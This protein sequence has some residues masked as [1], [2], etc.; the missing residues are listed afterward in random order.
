M[1]GMAIC[2]T[3]TALYS[4]AVQGEIAS[5]VIRLHVLANSDSPEDQALK[6]RVRDAVLSELKT[7]LTG[8]EDLKTTRAVLENHIPDIKRAAG[9][10]TDYPVE[11]S[12]TREFFPTRVYGGVTLP[13]GVYETLTVS[14][15]TAAGRNW[16]CVVFPPMC[17]GFAEVVTYENMPVEPDGLRNVLSAEAY[18]VVSGQETVR[19][20]FKAV[21]IWQEIKNLFSYKEE[22]Q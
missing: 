1:A 21:E 19:I 9:Y 11:A 4:N 3:V 7:W 6:F 14:I 13:A 10:H 20:K 18:N 22:R 12:L 2:L 5:E 17:L 8:D 15:G 16:W